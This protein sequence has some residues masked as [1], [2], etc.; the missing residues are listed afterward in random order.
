LN[1]C[2]PTPVQLRLTGDHWKWPRVPSSHPSN[3]PLRRGGE[4]P[5]NY[6]LHEAWRLHVQ[7]S[8][9][10]A[11]SLPMH[12]QPRTELALRK[13]SITF[14]TDPNQKTCVLQ[15]GILSGSKRI[16]PPICHEKTGRPRPSTRLV[17][18]VRAPS[19]FGTD[20][21]RSAQPVARG[22]GYLADRGPIITS[23]TA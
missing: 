3:R 9:K 18:N 6:L 8:P 5:E 15:I 11:I 16:R 12:R 21:T 1:G 22:T 20:V 14:P 13:A 10:E 19:P 7:S 4:H 17:S 2:R 23:G